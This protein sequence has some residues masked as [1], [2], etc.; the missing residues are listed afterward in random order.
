MIVS[1]TDTIEAY[2]VYPGGQSGNPG[3]PYYDGF[4]DH[5]A[6]GKY[7]RLWFMRTED[8]D[9]RRVKYKIEFEK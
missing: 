4:I 8:K 2:G 9:N 6:A 3:S 5:W 1:L 7:Y